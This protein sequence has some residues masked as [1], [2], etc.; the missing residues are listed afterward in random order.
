[1]DKTIVTAFLVITGIISSVMVFNAIYPAL[2]QSS[3]AITSMQGRIDD[4]LKSQIGIIHAVKIDSDVKLWVKNLGS[5]RIG[6]VE[7]C[8][9]FFGPDG[10]FA[11]IPYGTGNPHWEYTVENDSDWN[12]TAT[13]RI[14][15][16]GYA[17]L[18]SG[19]YY[20][21]LILPNGVSDQTF[22]SW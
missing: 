2:G 5:L 1:M 12:P 4:R 18:T 15:I 3:D 13:I 20:A 22:F 10:N 19:R 17:P 21:K 9:L 8:D 11:R 14:S 7:A 16:V 6:A